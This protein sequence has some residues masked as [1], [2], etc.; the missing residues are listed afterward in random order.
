KPL[1]QLRRRYYFSFSQWYV[2]AIFLDDVN[3]FLSRFRI[4]SALGIISDFNCL[5]NHNLSRIRRNRT[6][7]NVEESRFSGSVF[8]NDA[9]S[10]ATLEIETEILQYHPVLKFLV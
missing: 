6:R 9:N 3:Y 8:T 5:A 1:E 7:Q 2:F 4:D 10:F